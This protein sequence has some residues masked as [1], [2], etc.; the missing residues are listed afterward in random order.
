[1]EKLY[2]YRAI[3][4]RSVLGIEANEFYFASPSDFIDPFDC[5][6][7][8]T[9]NGASDSD[10]RIFLTNFLVH[11]EPNLTEQSRKE[12]VEKVIRSGEHRSREKLT[13][14]G[15]IWGQ[16]LANQSRKLGIVCLS[17]QPDDILMWAHYGNSHRGFC[18]EFDAEVLR[19]YC[20]CS[21]VRYLKHYP[22]FSEFVRADP[23]ECARTFVLTKSNHW[24]YEKEVRLVIN[25]ETE[26]GRELGRVVKY[27]QDSLTGIIFGCSISDEDKQI[28][29]EAVIKN[30]ANVTLYQCVKSAS[31][32]SVKIE[33]I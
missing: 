32:Y 13:E 30:G 4:E 22:T 33:T 1:M 24:E 8:I 27:P 9:F 17:E 31:S 7:L 11:K 2:R 19:K 3:T 16:I 20:Y 29:T 21:R 14:L 18:L 10:W 25:T 26:D 23:E 28:V 12:A 15:V 5:K 6:N